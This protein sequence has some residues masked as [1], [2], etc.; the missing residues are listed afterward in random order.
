MDLDGLLKSTDFPEINPVSLGLDNNLLKYDFW[1]SDTLYCQFG[2]I[3]LFDQLNGICRIMSVSGQ[4]IEGTYR[5][6]KITG[7]CRIISGP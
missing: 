7:F 5:K 2:Q 3:N 4:I 6:D 1:I